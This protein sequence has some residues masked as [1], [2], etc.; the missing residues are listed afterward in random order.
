MK[1]KF[2]NLSD[3]SK[4]VIIIY[5][6]YVLA[7]LIS[8]LWAVTQKRYNGDYDDKAVFLSFGELFIIFIFNVIP[9]FLTLNIYFH[10]KKYRAKKYVIVNNSKLKIFTIFMQMIYLSFVI[11]YGVGRAGGEEY[12]APGPIKLLIQIVIRLFPTTWGTV[13]LYSAPK[14]LYKS[15]ILIAFIYIVITILSLS[16]GWVITVGSVIFLL[17]YKKV[18]IFCK[19]HIV[20]VIIGITIIPF[21]VGFAYNIRDIMRGQITSAVSFKP[22]YLIFSKLFG[23]FSSFSATA[24]IYDYQDFFKKKA[25]S[26]DSLFYQKSMLSFVSSKFAP[27]EVFEKVVTMRDAKNYS[28]MAG[29]SGILLFS[30]YIDLY[31][32]IMNTLCI[33][34]FVYLIFFLYSKLHFSYNLEYCALTIVM[35][36]V[37]GTGVSIFSSFFGIVV[38]LVGTLVINKF[39]VSI[40]ASQSGVQN[41]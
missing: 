37:A 4:V 17:N 41:E 11:L 39:F 7:S 30:Y 34:C 12:Y 9:I 33:F 23:R 31:T 21:L 25:V 18:I 1:C 20:L 27:K 14:R 40:K 28:F 6:F 2:K 26:F 24:V 35:T 15:K 5:L 16:M 10:F 38:L 22:G 29:I 3:E 8:F 32:F 19:K 13:Y 36:V